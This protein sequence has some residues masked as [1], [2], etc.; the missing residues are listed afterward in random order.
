[1]ILL[2]KNSEIENENSRKFLVVL[3][4]IRHFSFEKILG[5]LWP[6]A[7]IAAHCRGLCQLG[8]PDIRVSIA[9][10]RHKK[11]DSARIAEAH[12]MVLCYTGR[13]EFLP[14]LT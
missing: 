2:A 4:L 6:E 11:L 7:T 10:K 9:G 3:G 14:N 12:F 13:Q 5:T 8:P 1:M